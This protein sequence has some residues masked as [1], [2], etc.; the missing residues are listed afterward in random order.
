MNDIS[1][2]A[3]SGPR[4][5]VIMLAYPSMTALDLIGPQAV[6]GFHSQT[7]L[8]WESRDPIL[9]DSGV[10]IV[11][12]TTFDECPKKA[13]V[14]FVPGGFGTWDVMG[15]ERALA[16]LRDR[17]P[18]ARYV[19]SVCTGALILAAAGLLD[20]HRAATH[21]STFEALDALGIKGVRERVVI[22]GNRITGGGVTAGIDFGL[23]VLAT[24][25]GEDVAKLAQLFLEYDP[26]PPFDAGSPARA[27][28]AITERVLGILG[29]DLKE[30]AMP[31]LQAARVRLDEHRR[32]AASA[33]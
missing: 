13:D 5:E 28:S 12:T 19:T 1:L 14:L 22:D 2:P 6:W 3:S 20:G 21:W 8:V 25:L 31:A 16:F 23:T 7:H 4:F 30:R 24:L 9:T 26:S 15:N 32:R 18:H 11:P 10:T 27:G 29:P 33:T 17:A